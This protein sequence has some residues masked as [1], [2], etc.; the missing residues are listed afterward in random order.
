MPKKESLTNSIIIDI[1]FF[2]ELD[3][4]T[5]YLHNVKRLT[6]KTYLKKVKKW[7]ERDLNNPELKNLGLPDNNTLVSWNIEILESPTLFK[8]T[9]STS[10]PLSSED[11]KYYSYWVTGL[12][13]GGNYPIEYY[14]ISYTAAMRVVKSKSKS[15]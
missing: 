6:P 15:K 10:K 11:K 14:K 12:D 2:A 4:K 5:I 3:D 1:R 8:F 13:D 7:F 9:Y